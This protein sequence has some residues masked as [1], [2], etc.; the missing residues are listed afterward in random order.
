MFLIDKRKIES[1]ALVRLLTP[2][3]LLT[4]SGGVRN[5]NERIGN[6]LKCVFEKVN[7]SNDSKRYLCQGDMS[8]IYMRS[9]RIFI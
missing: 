8:T 3:V 1:N 7:N 4:H 6:C 9:L 5:I 2:N